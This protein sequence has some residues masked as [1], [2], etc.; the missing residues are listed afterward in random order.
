[1][2]SRRLGSELDDT[3]VG[4]FGVA[5]TSLAAWQASEAL[6][7]VPHIDLD[8]LIPPDVRVVVVAPHPDDETLACGGL[9]AGLAERGSAVTLV[10]VTDGEASHPNS[11]LWSPAHLRQVRRSESRRAIA[12]LGF[13]P[14]LLHWQYL[15][16]PDGG[17]ATHVDWLQR[18]LSALLQ[19][20]DRVLTTWRQDGHCD[21]EAVGES[22]ARCVHRAGAH[23][24]EMPVWAWHWAAPDDPRLPWARACK[25]ILTAE[26][27]LRKRRAISAHASQ[28][29]A[30]PT[31]GA[32]AVLEPVTLER[33][34]QPFELVFI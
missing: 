33:L 15:G 7:R 29:Y 17:V 12:A 2:M 31:T 4:A 25:L 27:R 30:D 34:V 9:L 14:A 5:G 21:H 10:A 18:C 1:M 22:V 26:Q 24:L 8:K 28:L 16:L 32:P 23:L 20:G 3:Q 19:P 11:A 6:A 13:P